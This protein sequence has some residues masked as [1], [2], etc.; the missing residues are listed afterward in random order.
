MSTDDFRDGDGDGNAANVSF[1]SSSDGLVGMP[2]A[3]DPQFLPTLCSRIEGGRS[4]NVDLLNV[5]LWRVLVADVIELEKML[6]AA[7][8]DAKTFRRGDTTSYIR[9]IRRVLDGA[10]SPG[11]LVLRMFV[12]R[13]VVLRIRIIF[14]FVFVNR[15]VLQISPRLSSSP[16]RNSTRLRYLRNSTPST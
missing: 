5:P 4:Y 6:K 16:S 11:M 8:F 9:K 10:Y 13:M 15:V 3:S 14:P 1:E 12:L 7:G 2:E